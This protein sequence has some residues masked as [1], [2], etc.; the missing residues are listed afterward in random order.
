MA[1]F[2]L[3]SLRDWSPIT[4]GELMAFELP[5]SGVRSVVFDLVSDRPVSVHAVSGADESW[6]VGAGEGQFSVKFVTSEAV[7]VAVF[8]SEDAVVYIRT[9]NQTQFVSESVDPSFTNPEPRRSGP[10]DEVKQMMLLMRYNQS[11]MD[12][13]LLT[14]RE[15]ADARMEEVIE[16]LTSAPASSPAPAPEDAA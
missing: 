7:G 13:Q 6:L 1:N 14:E 3:G 8:G 15:A 12:A 9:K 10:P 11:R 4:V 2:N 5:A 16:R